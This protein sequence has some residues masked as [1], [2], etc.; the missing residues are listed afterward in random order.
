MSE[1]DH[2]N[3]WNYKII[4]PDNENKIENINYKLIKNFFPTFYDEKVAIKVIY[5]YKI[6]NNLLELKHIFF[7]LNKYYN[8][9]LYLMKNG[10]INCRK[11]IQNLNIFHTKYENLFKFNQKINLIEIFLQD[12]IL[13]IYFRK[14]K[15][16]TIKLIHLYLNNNSNILKLII[17]KQLNILIKFIFYFEFDYF[18]YN[19]ILNEFI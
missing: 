7:W 16:K 10:I 3:I 9:F 5:N 1:L 18:L 6:K 12:K 15:I 13:Q 4:I 8:E 19:F 17:K 11:E 14:L 2:N